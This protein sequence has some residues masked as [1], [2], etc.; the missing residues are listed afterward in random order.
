[1]EFEYKGYTGELIDVDDSGRLHGRVTNISDVVD[2]KAHL[3]RSAV[4]DLGGS[5]ELL[6]TVDGTVYESEEAT[7]PCGCTG[8]AVG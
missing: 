3:Y 6:A 5:S 7:R 8:L 2:F 4:R 1:M